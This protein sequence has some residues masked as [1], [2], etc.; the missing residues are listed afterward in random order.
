MVCLILPCRSPTA[1]IPG[2]LE[3]QPA[4]D[5]DLRSL[6][7]SFLGYSVQTV[8]GSGSRG[9]ILKYLQN[10]DGCNWAISQEFVISSYELCYRLD[11][12]RKHVWARE[13]ETV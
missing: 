5:L 7:A 2:V 3:P 11:R 12:C 13:C 4:D 6:A 9:Q 10:Y 8:E 1:P